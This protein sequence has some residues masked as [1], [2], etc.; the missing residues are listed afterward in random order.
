MKKFLLALV[1]LI[2]T[3]TLLSCSAPSAQQQSVDSESD[4]QTGESESEITS[5]SESAE[6]TETQ[7]ETQTESAT[8]SETQTESETETDNGETP[9]VEIPTI[10]IAEALALC[11]EPGNITT[12][13][14]YIKGIIKTVSNAEYGTMVSLM[15][16][17]RSRYTAP[18]V[19]TA[20]FVTVSLTKSLTRAMRFFFIVSSRTTTAQRK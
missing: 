12:E 11:G 19:L 17:E 18:T 4:S 15:Q 9:D 6:T 16:Q 3:A 5:E 7:T 8:E 10:T 1:A 13:R 20:S 2:L 14:Y